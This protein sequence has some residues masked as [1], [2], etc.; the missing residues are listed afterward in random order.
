[1]LVT[2][3]EPPETLLIRD[4]PPET[5]VTRDEPPE[6]LVTRD[7]PHDMVVLINLKFY[8]MFF[9]VAENGHKTTTEEV[10]FMS[11]GNT[12]VIKKTERTVIEEVTE[13]V[14]I[15][16]LDYS[17]NMNMPANVE[18]PIS[19]DY[20]DHTYSNVIYDTV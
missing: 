19:R 13:T 3:D 14:E 16:N 4:E 15:V 5:L 9:W 11:M 10:S 8:L 6:T 20:S 18:V 7:E 2:R 1:M 17:N 12:Q